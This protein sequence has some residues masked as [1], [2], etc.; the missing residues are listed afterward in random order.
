[1]TNYEIPQ[2]PD[3]LQKPRHAGLTMVM[4]K[5]L[6]LRQAEDLAS[7]A[8]PYIDFLKLGWSTSYLTPN[9]A[10]KVKL[11]QQ[12]GIS[13]FFGGTLMEVFIARNAFDDFRRLLDRFALSHVEVSS[14]SLDLSLEDKVNYIRRLKAHFTVLSEIG[15]KD[16]TKVMAPYLWVEHIRA[17][18][19]AGSTL[20]ITEARESGT[21]GI[22]RPTGE[23]RTGLID[24][25]LHAIPADK[26][27]FEA[28]HKA[29]QTWFIKLL[30]PNV[31]LGNVDPN[32]II[33]LETLR[34]GLRG[35]TFFDFL[36]PIDAN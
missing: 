30:G 31:N 6:S 24:E 14:G 32:D 4:D 2:L 1:M 26:L 23:I 3:R 11:Y 8:A 21:V 20:V 18:L 29:Q 5:G 33:G 19:D 10:D 25:I 22:F 35:D 27:L 36:S 17:E 28:P 12:A 34:L 7:N 9:L 16:S 13:V 15:S